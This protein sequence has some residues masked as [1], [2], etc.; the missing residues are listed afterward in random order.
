[1]NYTQ[2]AFKGQLKQALRLG[3]KYLVIVG[4]EEFSKG[5]VGIKNTATEVQEEVPMG[6]ITKYLK[7]KVGK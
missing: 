6:R 7:E 2:K 3:A 4:E 1:M 5:V